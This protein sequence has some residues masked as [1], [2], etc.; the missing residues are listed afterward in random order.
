MLTRG[1]ETPRARP[2]SSINLTVARCRSEVPVSRHLEC[3]RA[4]IVAPWML[5]SPVYGES[6]REYAGQARV[7]ASDLLRYRYAARPEERRIRDEFCQVTR[8]PA[9][10]P[11]SC[12]TAQRGRGV[13][14][15]KSQV[16]PVL[17]GLPRRSAA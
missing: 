2:S 12:V 17:W 15:F 9:S 16:S 3:Y 14:L 1:P 5:L 4:G 10:C 8:S 7:D 11:S 13:A 6:H